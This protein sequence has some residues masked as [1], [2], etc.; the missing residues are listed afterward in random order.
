MK[1]NLPTEIVEEAEF[2]PALRVIEP[3]KTP[4]RVPLMSVIRDLS[5][6]LRPELEVLGWEA[7]AERLHGCG[8]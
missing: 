7:R 4:R 2:Q 1:Q 6:A 3:S 5:G 8:H